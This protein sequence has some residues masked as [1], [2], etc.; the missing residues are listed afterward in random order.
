M[1]LTQY[2]PQARLYTLEELLD[3]VESLTDE[4]IQAMQL[5]IED[6]YDARRRNGSSI[7]TDR[8]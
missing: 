3:K 1:G 4:Y 5:V 2:D 6:Y 8:K 7:P